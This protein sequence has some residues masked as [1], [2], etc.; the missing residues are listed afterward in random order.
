M[1]RATSQHSLTPPSPGTKTSFKPAD[2]TEIAKF[3]DVCEHAGI[4]EDLKDGKRK[5]P[6][7]RKLSQQRLRAGADEDLAS[8]NAANEASDNPAYPRW[9]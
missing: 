4:A 5:N 3:E 2:V 6:A 7:P 1:C 8:N 9:L